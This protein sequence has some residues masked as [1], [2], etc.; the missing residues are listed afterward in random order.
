[1]PFMTS[2]LVF[3]GWGPLTHLE[4]PCER[5]SPLL[6]GALDPIPPVVED[7]DDAERVVRSVVLDVAVGSQFQGHTWMHTA[8]EKGGECRTG[9]QL[10]AF[11]CRWL[12][13]TMGEHHDLRVG[14]ICRADGHPGCTWTMG[15]CSPPGTSNPNTD[16]KY[17]SVSAG[18][19][20]MATRHCLAPPPPATHVSECA[21]RFAQRGSSTSVMAT[22]ETVACLLPMLLQPTPGCID[23]DCSSACSLAR[24][25]AANGTYLPLVR[26]DDIRDEIK[27]AA[28]SPKTVVHCSGKVGQEERLRGESRGK[29]ARAKQPA[30]SCLL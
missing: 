17:C 21:I 13:N 28:A 20:T 4:V 7:G 25:C 18:G 30:A 19:A 27:A 6:C 5:V 10:H 3:W 12:Q 23:G 2:V 11:A 29:H 14:Y 26:L 9:H 22:C 16:F 24:E 8:G 15:S 1:M